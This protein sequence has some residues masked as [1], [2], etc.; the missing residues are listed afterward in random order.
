MLVVQNLLAEF[1]FLERLFFWRGCKNRWVFF[2]SAAY[3]LF[4][5]LDSVFGMQAI[6]CLF[7]AYYWYSS[8][9]NVLMQIKR[10]RAWAG[11]LSSYYFGVLGD[12]F[13]IRIVLVYISFLVGSSMDFWHL[14]CTLNLPTGF[15]GVFLNVLDVY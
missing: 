15:S 11:I 9:P 10:S 1:F 13:A 7:D 6:Y 12:I 8:I 14:I 5:R 2:I 3:L 4:T